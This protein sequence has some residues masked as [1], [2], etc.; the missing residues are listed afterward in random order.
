M[1]SSTVSNP[2][3]TES[4]IHMEQH[5]FTGGTDKEGK[6][7][8]STASS[9]SRALL[10]KQ[11]SETD[12]GM[13]QTG[14]YEAFAEADKPPTRKYNH[15]TR[16][17][18]TTTVDVKRPP[19]KSAI[20][21]NRLKQSIH[22][23][24]NTRRQTLSG[25]LM[26]T[27]SP[28]DDDNH[29]NGLVK[30]ADRLRNTLAIERQLAKEELGLYNKP[31]VDDS[32]S[33][34][35]R[36]RASVVKEK[37]RT[38]NDQPRRR[39]LSNGASILPQPQQRVPESNYMKTTKAADQ[40]RRH[41]TA[42]TTTNR[43]SSA[44]PRKTSNLSRG[45]ATSPSITSE[46]E[47]PNSALKRRTI[48]AA[49]T[50]KARQQ[51]DLANSSSSS[52][53][54]TITRLRKKSIANENPVDSI[55]ANRRMSRTEN[56]KDGLPTSPTIAARMARRKSI[57]NSPSE[58]QHTAARMARRKSTVKSDSPSGDHPNLAAARVARRK[59]VV[60]SPNAD[61]SLAARMARRKSVVKNESPN[62]DQPPTTTRRKSIV[63]TEEVEKKP[64]VRK[65][66]KT[67]PGSLAKPP[68]VQS[69]Q[70]PPMKLEPIKL[71]IPQQKRLAPKS[72]SVKAISTTSTSRI[73]LKQKK[74]LSI[75]SSS[76][77]TTPIPISSSSS[78]SAEVPTTIVTPPKKSIS[79]RKA[80]G[81]SHLGISTSRRPSLK[82]PTSAQIVTPPLKNSPVTIPSPRVRPTPTRRSSL[83]VP[84]T[85]KTPVNDDRK[86]SVSGYSNS[87]RKNSVEESVDKG[88]IGNSVHSM[89]I[90]ILML[91]IFF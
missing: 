53:E 83:A 42:N 31:H 44:S 74:R 75:S 71:N 35:A 49:A 21:S 79:T 22:E 51:L 64:T 17:K 81:Q 87:S 43:L 65:R 61:Q 59:S 5:R 91:P 78:S 27:A 39:T 40:Q 12:I 24:L 38:E 1:S 25:A 88:I 20:D 11:S 55:L 68:V 37:L 76:A 57:V 85:K 89:L 82:T 70:L 52:D 66:G 2:Y 77:N 45:D 73:S 16:R 18:S 36:R 26:S 86:L 48:L 9:R 47:K 28:K 14:I 19:I 10:N 84:S 29:N 62:G 58:E 80:K 33:A 32:V 50:V 15:D 46:D 4:W 56:L 72:P 90:S 23:K 69:L 67:L 63:K 3:I 8:R 41:S 7:N 6:V 30:L 54:P 60:N 34:A 13:S